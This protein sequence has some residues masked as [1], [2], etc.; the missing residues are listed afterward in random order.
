MKYSR[1][2]AGALIVC[3]WAWMAAP[4]VAQE[5]LDESTIVGIVQSALPEVKAAEIQINM[6][7]RLS[8]RTK[9]NLEI[10]GGNA[11]LYLTWQRHRTG[12]RWWFEKDAENSLVLLSS[13]SGTAR[14]EGSAP[15]KD[16]PPAEQPRTETIEPSAPPAQEKPAETAPPPASEKPAMK[17]EPKTAEPQPV[18]AE[19]MAKQ[20]KPVEKPAAESMP[21]PEPAREQPKEKQEQPAEVKPV[22]AEP[23]SEPKELPPQ[24]APVREAAVPTAEEPAAEGDSPFVPIELATGSEGTPR[25]FIATLVMVLGKGQQEYYTRFL[26]RPAEMAV[27]VKEQDFQRG[28]QLW[29]DQF[30]EIHQELRKASHVGLGRITLQKPQ[31]AEIERATLSSLNRRIRSVDQVYTYVKINLTLDDQPAYISIGGL[32]H[33]DSGWRIGGRVELVRQVSLQ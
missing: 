20:S 15:G 32:L 13:T 25:E 3:A 19:P 16:E 29:T 4:V 22:Q 5:K 2:I 6:I 7:K 8:S 23:R 11:I 17:S 27:E 10:K 26:L 12:A 14:R 21:K 33:T 9:V 24:P 1:M 18:A 30:S 28:V 31:T